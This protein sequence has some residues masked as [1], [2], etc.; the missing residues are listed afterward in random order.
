[1]PAAFETVA[2]ARQLL[3]HGPLDTGM[4]RFAM[5]SQTGQGG[6]SRSAAAPQITHQR[7]LRLGLFTHQ[8]W[9]SWLRCDPAAFETVA[10]ARQ[11]LLHG[12]LDTGMQR[13]AMVSQ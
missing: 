12:P 6:F 9:P 10:Q 2:Q 13:F 11:L 5:V 8:P 1:D 4:Q 3:L 7:L